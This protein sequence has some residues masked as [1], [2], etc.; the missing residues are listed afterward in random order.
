VINQKN[1]FANLQV[2]VAVSGKLDTE[3]N[4]VFTGLGQTV[5]SYKFMLQGKEVL[6][7]T[8]IA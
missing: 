2:K 3:L 7:D 8:A 6:K 1:L 5:G 4:K